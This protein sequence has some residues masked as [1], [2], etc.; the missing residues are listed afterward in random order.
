M[1]K[2]VCEMCEG[3]DFIKQEG[4]FVCQNCGT[5]YS[6]EE[7]RKIMNT[8]G[9][10]APS[11][12]NS[13][14]ESKNSAQ[15]EN[16]LNLAQSSFDSKNY[17]QAEEF[18]NQILAN[19]S[20][21]Y[22]AWKLKGE[23]INYQINAN[24]QRILE[25]YNCLMTS[26]KVLDAA[27][28]EEHKYDI[29]SSIKSCFESEIDFWLDQ[30]E[31]QRPTKAAVNKVKSTFNDSIN[32]LLE[33]YREMGIEGFEEYKKI[34]TNYFIGEVNVK[35]VS[36]WKTTVGYNYYRDSFEDNNHTLEYEERYN[37]NYNSKKIRWKFDDYRPN[38]ETFRTF[39]NECDNLI[40]LLLFSADL[41]NDKTE[42]SDIITTYENAI[43]LNTHV[44]FGCSFK[45]MVSTTTNGYGAVTNRKEYWELD[46]NLTKEA[47]DF[48]IKNNSAYKGKIGILVPEYKQQKDLEEKI[49]ELDRRINSLI[50]VRK[51][52]TGCFFWFFMIFG[53]G[54]IPFFTK[55]PVIIAIFAVMLIVTL[56][57]GLR[58]TP[59]EEV[60]AQNII[61]QEKLVKEKKELEKELEKFQ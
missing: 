17:A 46:K 10:S 37:Y 33:T 20:S 28:K 43:F 55:A 56:I 53:I 38:T 22:D 23:A 49:A 39:I 61:E 27:G 57:L 9:E 26:Y 2:L 41:F 16:L 5:K 3:S 25:V 19:D 54:A 40:S 11:V 60:V 47:L 42:S 59:S 31:A 51:R 18:C 13:V 4:L 30:M 7:A 35:C 29:L 14:V 34:F 8:D 1:G 12:Q 58:K 21:N 50:T 44:M 24:N 52:N 48:R 45:R 15:L 6:V 32:K 36:T